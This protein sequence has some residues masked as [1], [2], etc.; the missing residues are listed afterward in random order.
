MKLIKNFPLQLNAALKRGIDYGLLRKVNGHYTLHP[1]P[2]GVNPF[3]IVP[4]EKAMRK[5]RR[6]KGAGRMRRGRRGRGARRTR[7]TRRSRRGSRSRRGRG[8][9]RRR[10]VDSKPQRRGILSKNQ[11]FTGRRMR[12]MND[13]LN[14]KCTNEMLPSERVR[15]V[16]HDLG[17]ERPANVEISRNAS[18]TNKERERSRSKSRRSQSQPRQQTRQQTPARSPCQ[19]SESSDREDLDDSN[20]QDE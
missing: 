14:V 20:N 16:N 11:E 3:G 18:T 8:G 19:S 12:R 7:R 9:Y 1:D 5:R 15:C 2:F 17:E 4:E 10:N 13:E 6:R